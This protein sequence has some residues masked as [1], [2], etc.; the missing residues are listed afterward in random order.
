MQGVGYRYFTERAA[1]RLGLQ[2]WVRNLADGTVE[3]Y[4]IGT[5]PQLSEFT[6]WLWKGPAHAE[7]R[8]VDEI[9]A[10]LEA[11]EGFRIRR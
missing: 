7:V 4:A 8:G 6:G 3:A 1:K 2:G 10:S 5:P 9:E 11:L